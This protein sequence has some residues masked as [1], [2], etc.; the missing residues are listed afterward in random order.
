M[1]WSRRPQPASRSAGAAQLESLGLQGGHRMKLKAFP[2]L[3]LF[4]FLYVCGGQNSMTQGA[5]APLENERVNVELRGRLTFKQGYWLVGQDPQNTGKQVKIKLLT[6]ENKVL[7]R[8]L[9]ELEGSDV[10]VR[11]FLTVYSSGD[12]EQIGVEDSFSVSRGD[13]LK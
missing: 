3:V 6:S 12:C 8:S 7:V 11:G 4:S 2:V 1:R 13:G 9:E 5:K 10:I